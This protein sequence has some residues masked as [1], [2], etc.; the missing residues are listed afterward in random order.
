[1]TNSEYKD[2]TAKANQVDQV[3]AAATQ[4]RARRE[5]PQDAWKKAADPVVAIAASIIPK[6]Q[7][8]LDS[9]RTASSEL[10]EQA[11]ARQKAILDKQAESD[12]VEREI[13]AMLG[14]IREGAKNLSSIDQNALRQLSDSLI[15][16]ISQDRL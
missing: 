14:S 10:S 3:F 6:L 11:T 2:F 1:M 5:P 8:H 9:L 7:S 4:R 12:A 16:L 13:A 15:P